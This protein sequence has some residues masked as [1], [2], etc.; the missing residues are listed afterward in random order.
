[1]PGVLSGLMIFS[2]RRFQTVSPDF[3]TYVAK[4][5]SKVRFSPMIMMTCLIGVWVTKSRARTMRAQ[6][7]FVLP[8]VGETFGRDCSA[9]APSGLRRSNSIDCGPFSTTIER[10]PIPRTCQ[11]SFS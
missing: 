3:D 6:S 8:S 11:P 2:E 5:L 9:G 1:M 4:R 7:L 10:K